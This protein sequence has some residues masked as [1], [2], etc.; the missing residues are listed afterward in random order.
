MGGG[1]L[2]KASFAL[3]HLTSFRAEPTHLSTIWTCP[4][5]RHECPRLVQATHRRDRWIKRVQSKTGSLAI[6][7]TLGLLRGVGGPGSGSLAGRDSFCSIC[8]FALD[9][10]RFRCENPY[11]RAADGPGESGRT[12]LR[13]WN[14]YRYMTRGGSS[15]HTWH[16][17]LRALGVASMCDGV[18][19]WM[20]RN[21]S[22]MRAAAVWHEVV[23]GSET[24]EAPN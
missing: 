3:T 5:H 21:T 7:G 4:G 1:R 19:V 23:G 24:A 18:G 9:T 8:G 16:P 22:A 15:M 13:K 6:F 14:T 17:T 12:K 20:Y 11:P 10:A 2:Q